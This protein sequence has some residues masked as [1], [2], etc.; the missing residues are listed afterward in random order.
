M[1]FNNTC[2]II[3]L[4]RNK[5]KFIREKE[6]N[7]MAISRKKVTDM[8]E[9]LFTLWETTYHVNINDKVFYTNDKVITYDSEDELFE[10]FYTT[11]RDFE[12]AI[13]AFRKEDVITINNEII[14]R[15]DMLKNIINRNWTSSFWMK[16]N[17]FLFFMNDCYQITTDEV[18]IIYNKETY[19]KI[20]SICLKEI[21]SLIIDEEVI[22]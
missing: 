7:T 14:I 21:N 17:G 15:E 3:I 19:R 8:K 12:H 13:Y 4:V 20:T 2:G 6:K 16:I 22:L 9:Y 10:I 11:D 18:L 5:N 1:T